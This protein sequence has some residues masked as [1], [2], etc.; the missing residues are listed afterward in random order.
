MLI[1]YINGTSATTGYL[2]LTVFF[3]FLVL[4]RGENVGFLGICLM[5]Q[6]CFRIDILQ[7]SWL[8]FQ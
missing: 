4:G 6:K 5:V 8:A 2:F 7:S 3:F 1:F